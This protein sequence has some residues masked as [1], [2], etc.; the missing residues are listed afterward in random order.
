MSLTD[1]GG[2]RRGASGVLT[3]RRALDTGD[4]FDRVI[5]ITQRTKVMVAFCNSGADDLR[6]HGPSSRHNVIIDFTPPA[7]EIKPSP[8]AETAPPLQAPPNDGVMAMQLIL[9]V[10]VF[11]GGIRTP[12][13]A[14]PGTAADWEGKGESLS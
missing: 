1:V 10:S 5:S 8:V 9:A 2:W 6:Y 14:L 12:S 11:R 13:M 4:S 3:F 7:K